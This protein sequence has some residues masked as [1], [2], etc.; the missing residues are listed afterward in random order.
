MSNLIKG[1]VILVFLSI[2]QVGFAKTADG[3]TPS[4]ETICDVFQGNDSGAFG[5]CNAY[6]EAMDCG[7]PL[8]RSSSRA[9]TKVNDNFEKKFG[10]RL[11]EETTINSEG[12]YVNNCVID[13]D[14]TPCGSDGQPA[15]PPIP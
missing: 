8:Q 3:E 14:E 9:C 1:I 2:S 5:L 15:C 12:V 6:C 13:E 11:P 10:M 7:D 4:A